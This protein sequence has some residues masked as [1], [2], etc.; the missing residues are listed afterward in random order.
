MHFFS[1]RH[2]YYSCV[3]FIIYLFII[4]ITKTYPFPCLYVC[5]YIKK[6]KKKVWEQNFS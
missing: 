3:V 1:A 6:W 5:I 2:V 4:I